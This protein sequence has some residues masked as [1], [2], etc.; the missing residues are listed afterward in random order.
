MAE[1]LSV[2]Q[3]WCV[4]NVGAALSQLRDIAIQIMQGKLVLAQDELAAE[5][6]KVCQTCSEF[7]KFSRQCRLCNCFMDMKT[8]ILDASCPI[9]HW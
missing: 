3:A 5:R 8:K 4:A 2:L 7:T 6:I 9:N 1:A